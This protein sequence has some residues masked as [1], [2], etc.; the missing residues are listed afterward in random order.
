MPKPLCVDAHDDY[1]LQYIERAPIEVGDP[2]F[3]HTSF[4]LFGCVKCRRVVAFPHQN[5]DLVE[6]QYR[7]QLARRLSL[8]GFWL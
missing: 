3:T 6:P 4:W 1:P 5:L 7:A 2:R 8:E